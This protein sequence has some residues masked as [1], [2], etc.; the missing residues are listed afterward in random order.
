M[1]VRSICDDVVIHSII[2][3]AYVVLGSIVGSDY[4]LLQR[5]ACNTMHYYVLL[6]ISNMACLD[7][8]LLLV[9]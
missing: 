2:G 1:A 8:Y 3:G 6:F 7:S 4:I 9:K 5:T